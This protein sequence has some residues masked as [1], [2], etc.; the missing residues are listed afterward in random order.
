[1]EAKDILS[2]I[3]KR[4]FYVSV[5]EINVRKDEWLRTSSI[6]Y[7]EEEIRQ[8]IQSLPVDERGMEEIEST[9]LPEELIVLRRVVN[10]GMA[11]KNPMNTVIITMV[12]ISL[13]LNFVFSSTFFQ[14]TFYTKDNSIREIGVEGVANMS[15]ESFASVV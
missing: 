5:A 3:L 7:L 8:C 1:M 14:L 4:D 2:R 10:M 9:L 11:D 13:Q 12:L 6:K 15:E